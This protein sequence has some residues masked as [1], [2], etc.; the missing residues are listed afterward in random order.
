MSIENLF[1]SAGLLT[2]P[3][4]ASST[5]DSFIFSFLVAHLNVVKGFP[6]GTIRTFTTY[7][8]I[9]I[10]NHS[11]N[12]WILNAF[13]LQLL[14]IYFRF[15]RVEWVSAC[16]EDLNVLVSSPCGQYSYLTGKFFVDINGGLDWNVDMS[17]ANKLPLTTLELPTVKGRQQRR[18]SILSVRQ[19][20]NCRTKQ[21]EVY[22]K[23]F[24]Q[25][26]TGIDVNEKCA[27]RGRGLIAA[28]NFTKN[29]IIVDYHAQQ[30]SKNEAEKI[31]VDDRSNYLFC[32]N[33]NLFWDGSP[34]SCACHPQSRLLGRLANFAVKNTTECNATPQLFQFKEAR[35][36]IFHTLI[37]V[38][39][40]EIKVGEEIRYDY[41]DK[42]CIE[43]F[44][45]DINLKSEFILMCH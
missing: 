11:Y 9:N 37:L 43:L 3:Y 12:N 2:L 24:L 7:D 25:Q 36:K 15:I 19:A 5:N 10:N 45:P 13:E 28:K 29:E 17:I 4:P 1:K 35:N 26:W 38:A 8:F 42:K 18:T 6:L 30:V 21:A 41:G 22:E 32:G 39:T 33:N 31:R 44:E 23:C 20:R 14:D 16:T 27:N 34:E 40:G